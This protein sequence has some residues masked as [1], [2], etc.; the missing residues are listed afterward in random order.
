MADVFVKVDHRIKYFA[1][2]G[3][4]S[5]ANCR[6]IK[7]IVLFWQCRVIYTCDGFVQFVYKERRAHINTLA[8]ERPVFKRIFTMFS[9][10]RRCA[11]AIVVQSA[12]NADSVIIASYSITLVDGR[13]RFCCA[14][15]T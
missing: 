12:I 2:I 4:T 13:C 5:R 7:R 9:F 1:H 6:I 11:I 10:I 14:Y 3:H 8:R 15:S